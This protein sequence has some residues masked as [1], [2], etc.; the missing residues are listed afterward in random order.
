MDEEYAQPIR[1]LR[2]T[3]KANSA[4]RRGGRIM[5]LFGAVLAV[6]LVLATLY[7]RIALTALNEEGVELSG[8]VT[9]LRKEQD[10][11]LIRRS[12]LY[13]L[14]RVEAYAVNELGMQRP[15]GEQISP[16]DTQRPDRVTLY[17]E[18]RER[19]GGERMI[20]L[21]DTIAACFR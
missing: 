19:S 12:E 3:P 1:S 13:D 11:L 21:L 4:R 7:G 8:A 10:R 9:A 2:K 18:N 14:E 20:S 15:R 5:L 17:P 16:L 6:G